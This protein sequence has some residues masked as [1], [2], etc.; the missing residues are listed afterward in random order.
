MDAIRTKSGVEVRIIDTE[1]GRFISLDDLIKHLEK[2]LGITGAK[3]S[4]F[5]S[6]LIFGLIGALKAM[7][8][9]R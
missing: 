7:R 8:E 5:I 2:S 6:R 3:G 9:I 1:D 4:D